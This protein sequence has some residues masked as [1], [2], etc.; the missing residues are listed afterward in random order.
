MFGPPRESETQS[1]PRNGCVSDVKTC[2]WVWVIEQPWRSQWDTLT[3]KLMLS[4]AGFRSAFGVMSAYRD[5][6]AVV[7]D[8]MGVP[9]RDNFNEEMTSEHIDACLSLL[10]KRMIGPKSKL[11]TTRACVVDTIF[12]DTICMLHTE[13]PTEDA[14]AKMQ[15]PDE[16]RG[17][18]K[19]ER[20]MWTI[21]VVDSARTSDAKDKGVCAG[22]MTPLTTMMPFICHQTSYFNNIRLKR[23]DLMSMPL[24][25]HLPKAKV[26]Q[27]N[28]SVSCGMFMMGFIEHILQSEKIEI[29]QNMIAKMRQQ[30]ALK[31]FSN[32]CESEP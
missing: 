28:D 13:F 2:L 3:K 14:R 20:P 21:K 10:C 1:T 8:S 4:L 30:Y 9:G 17:Y 11:Y 5:V 26:H 16:L 27:Q 18:V 29:K 23:R 19:G 31:I 22:Q 12:F 25:I 15:I 7:T 32:S 6:A 24:D